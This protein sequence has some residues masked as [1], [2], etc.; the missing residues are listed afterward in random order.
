M[1]AYDLS[2]Y[3]NLWIFSHRIH[4]HIFEFISLHL[5]R[6]RWV[7]PPICWP[8]CSHFLNS[9]RKLLAHYQGVP[10]CWQIRWINSFEPSPARQ[11]FYWNLL[12][13][14]KPNLFKIQIK[15][16]D[17]IRYWPYLCKFSNACIRCSIFGS[18]WAIGSV[19][20]AIS[21]NSSTFC[22]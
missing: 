11:L 17:K 4:S 9:Q 7:V 8:L 20:L 10:Y 16:A 22:S 2:L 1:N 3:F 5:I 15:F 6:M 14:Y 18:N 12:L 21:Y 19:F 13:K